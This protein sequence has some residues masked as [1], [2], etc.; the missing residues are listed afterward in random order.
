MKANMVY[1]DFQVFQNPLIVMA[2]DVWTVPPS[3]HLPSL[4]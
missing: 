1:I 4:K 2:N 3:C